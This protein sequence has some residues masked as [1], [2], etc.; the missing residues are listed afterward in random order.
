[1]AEIIAMPKLG[2][3][4][5]EG[6]LNR[7]ILAE[8]DTASKGDV[9]AEIETDKATVEVEA[10][11]D[12]V[13]LKHLVGE[14]TSVPIG[15]PIAVF[16]AEGEDVDLDK[17]LP[18]N[19]KEAASP[20]E[21]TDPAVTDVE[22]VAE[23][24]QEAPDDDEAQFPAGVRI[25][26]LA[27]RMAKDHQLDIRT[28]KGSGPLG[29]IVKRDIEAALSAPAAAPAAIAFTP[30]EDQRIPVSKLRSAIGRRMTA[31]KQQLPHFYVTMDMDASAL[32]HQRSTINAL[33]PDEEKL[34]V[35][36]FIVKATALALVEHPNLNSS[37]QE[38]TILVH[39]EVNVGIAV[40]VDDGLLTVVTRNTDMKSLR[41]I[42]RETREM[43]VR[44]RDGRVR[45]EDVE[46]STF[47]ISNLG[48][49][50]V[51]DFIAIINPPE[52]AIL[53]IGGIRDVPVVEDGEIV[54]GKRMK[55][56]LSADHRVADGVQAAQWLQTFKQLI[57]NPLKLLL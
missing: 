50:G 32:M 20:V 28:I 49:F 27:R 39:G 41:Q 17:L 42:A 52:S 7:W 6:T 31:S 55:V 5:A 33:L 43:I 15:E 51:D 19:G 46:G 37:L 25:S 29:R 4:M 38:D 12:G 26:P 54:P 1:M 3:D 8:G 24:V 22:A 44:A 30:R 47:T 13:L 16:G 14:G 35:N 10:T 56:T 40:A 9:I 18:S 45:P 23:P 34:S 57:E 53:A 11:I 2:F 36:D 21:P 48:M